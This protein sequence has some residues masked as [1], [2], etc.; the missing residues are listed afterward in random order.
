MCENCKNF[1]EKKKLKW[2][3]VV[4]WKMIKTSIGELVCPFGTSNQFQV[5][6]ITEQLVDKKTEITIEEI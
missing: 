4:E 2:K 1:E 6:S 3:G 5:G